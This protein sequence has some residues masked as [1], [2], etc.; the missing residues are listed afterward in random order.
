MSSIKK[1]LIQEIAESLDS[2]GFKVYLSKDKNHGFYTNGQRVVSFGSS[3]HFCVDFSGNYAPS[4]HGGTGWQVKT[5]QTSITEDQANAYI[6]ANAPSWANKNP[7]YTTPE[8]HLK[9]YGQSS[10]YE[11]FKPKPSNPLVWGELWDAMK[12]TPS[13]WIET[14]EEMHWDMLECLPPKRMESRK[15]LVGEADHHN[16]QGEAVFACFKKVGVKFFARYLTIAQFQ[17][18]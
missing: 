12:E 10:G 3:W 8:Q 15:F 14:T 13:A 9:T 11:E 7:T 1:Q 5:E 2:F 17:Y 16:E 6:V 4:K 18:A